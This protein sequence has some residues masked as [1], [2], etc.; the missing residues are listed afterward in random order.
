MSTT[1]QGLIEDRGTAGLWKLL[2]G[3]NPMN[4]WQGPL[5][6]N[7]STAHDQWSFNS[8][9]DCG[10]AG[11]LFRLDEDPTEHD[12]RRGSMPHL[13]AELL[14]TIRQLNATTFSPYR[15]PGEATQDTHA[16]CAAAERYGGFFGPY[17]EF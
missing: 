5:Y 3:R 12:D 16:A 8:I 17:V 15:G 14:D 6:P 4:G 9:F 2:L 11:C 10:E 1:V 7:A 13:A